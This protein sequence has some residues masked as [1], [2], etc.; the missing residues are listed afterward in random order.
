MPRLRQLR[1]RLLLCRL[2][3]NRLLLLP[4]LPLR[5]RL[6]RVRWVVWFP[7]LN[8]R[9]GMTSSMMLRLLLSRR[10]SPSLWLRLLNRLLLLRRKLQNWARWLR[11]WKLPWEI[12]RN[13]RL[14]KLRH[15]LLLRGPALLLLRCR[16]CLL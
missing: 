2:N 10:L 1:L 16:R 4:N 3:R 7:I 12:L 11:I 9:W 5:Q 14:C 15:R 6:L 13:L 8:L